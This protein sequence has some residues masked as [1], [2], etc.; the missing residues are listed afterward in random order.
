MKLVEKRN[1]AQGLFVKSSLNRK[2]IAQQ[3][4]VTEKTLRSWIEAGEWEKQKSAMQI[5][6][7]QLLQEAYTQLQA[8][9]Q[10]I[11]ETY[12]GI[13]T[14]ELSDVKAVLRKEIESFSW[15]PI[16]KYIEVFED[17]L[18]YL[19]KTEPAK[20]QSFATLSQNFINQLSKESK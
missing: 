1:L 10:V 2:E 15:Q 14:K 5:T 13:P 17:F 19:S 4:G 16:H 6:R 8:V 11:I 12:K 18:A 9:N 3:I 20:L 7:P